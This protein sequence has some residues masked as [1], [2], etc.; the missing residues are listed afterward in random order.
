[1][2]LMLCKV[3]EAYVAAAVSR[4]HLVRSSELCPF[5]SFQLYI[6]FSPWET[7]KWFSGLVSKSNFGQVLTKLKGLHLTLFAYLVELIT[8]RG[9]GGCRAL[10]EAYILYS[11]RHIY[12]LNV[13]VPSNEG[14]DCYALDI[15]VPEPCPRKI[16]IYNAFNKGVLLV[17]ILS[18]DSPRYHP[19]QIVTPP[20]IQLCTCIQTQWTIL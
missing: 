17:W 6:C 18:P 15:H 11:L 12:G 1:M 2:Q 8:I 14:N 4:R 13:L 5:Y 7:W 3:K 20:A 9:G 19:L 10:S 16:C